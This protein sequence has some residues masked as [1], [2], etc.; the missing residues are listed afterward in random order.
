MKTGACIWENRCMYLG[1]QVHVF[2][3]TGAPVWTD[4]CT[5]SEGSVIPY[6]ELTSYW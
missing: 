2:G 3:K 1:K 4:R 6:P 5:R